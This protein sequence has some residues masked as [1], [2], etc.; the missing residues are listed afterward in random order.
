MKRMCRYTLLETL[1]VGVL[2]ILVCSMMLRGYYF[3]HRSFREQATDSDRMNMLLQRQKCFQALPAWSSD[4]P[5]E[6]KADGLWIG[7]DWQFSLPEGV[8]GVLRIESVGKERLAIIDCRWA[9]GVPGFLREH[10][11]RLVKKL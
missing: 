2:T 1:Y 11:L 3:F 10:H 5:A 8:N 6:L 7:G 4:T 9:S